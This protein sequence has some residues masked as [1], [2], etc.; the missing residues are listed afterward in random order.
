MM[1]IRAIES[2]SVHRI[3]SSQVIVDL[4]TAVK[5]LVENSLDAGATAIEVRF[6]EYGADLIE[7][8]DNGTG[9]AVEDFNALTAKHWTSKL[10]QFDD[11]ESLNSFGFRGEALSSLCAVASVSVLTR[12]AQDSV[13]TRI[14]YDH[15]GAIAKQTAAAREVGTTVSVASLFQNLPVR[16]HEFKRNLKTHFAKA[17]SLLQ[18]YALMCV[19]CRLVVSHERAK[20]RSTVLATQMQNNLK[21]NIVSI[22]GAKLF[23]SLMEFSA[24]LDGESGVT[25]CGYISRADPGCGRGQK[26]MQYFYING[27]PVNTPKS[28]DKVL[29]E[30]YRLFNVQQSPVFILNLK[31][32]PDRYDINVTPDKRSVLLHEESSLA[33]SIKNRLTASYESTRSMGEP[34]AMFPLT[35]HFQTQIKPD[36]IPESL[37]DDEPIPERTVSQPLPPPSAPLVKQPPPR[38]PIDSI[39]P[40]QRSEVADN[41]GLSTSNDRSTVSLPKTPLPHLK[42]TSYQPKPINVPVPT[43]QLSRQS[44]GAEK[45]R[46]IDS[47]DNEPLPV[48]VDEDS[49][50]HQRLSTGSRS[51]RVHWT[52]QRLREAERVAVEPLQMTPVVTVPRAFSLSA[53]CGEGSTD[54]DIREVREG[55]E[56]RQLDVA[57]QKTNFRKMEIIG[58]FNLG[59]I[60]TRLGSDLF[61]VDQHA[62]DEKYN[63]EALEKGSAVQTQRLLR[64]LPL[65]TTAS[66]ELVVLDH[67]DVFKRNGFEIITGQVGSSKLQ[68]STLPYSGNV[69]FGLAD[70]HDLIAL[71]SDSPGSDLS[72]PK[73]R[74]VRASRACRMSVMIGDPL[75]R[76][77][78][79]QLVSHMADM[80]QPWNCPHGRPTMRHLFALKSPSRAVRSRPPVHLR[81]WL[82]SQLG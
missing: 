37:S 56:D 54:R 51:S 68:V 76:R 49:V 17:V 36:P 13:G 64:P 22:L 15:E 1:H 61:I 47:F 19:G 41:A 3:C 30:T 55:V 57:F 44:A 70:V 46:K 21:A 63:F 10:S 45:K 4:K 5:E 66:N 31:S 18:A 23:T 32:A 38:P 29:N 74:A 28:I 82:N 72:I 79:A 59:F 43:G 58:Q 53:A 35:H 26:D 52:L 62:T 16:Q 67:I 39:V 2:A 14:Q 7:V 75:D 73:L 80:N 25:L 81:R 8:S 33:E 24:D 20:S 78:M 48:T 12:T 71:L 34:M 65:E 9:V 60:V 50:S 40:P 69:T 6:K 27:R 42:L 11:L 77:Q